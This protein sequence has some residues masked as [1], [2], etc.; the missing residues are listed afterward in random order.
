MVAVNRAHALVQVGDYAGAMAVWEDADRTLRELGLVQSWLQIDEL[1]ALARAGL[2]L[3]VLQRAAGLLQLRL[4]TRERA[5]IELLIADAHRRQGDPAAA[6]RGRPAR[7]AAAATDRRRPRRVAG[8]GDRGRG[9]ARRRAEGGPGRR[10]AGGDSRPQR[11]RPAADGARREPPEP[12]RRRP[13]AAARTRARRPDRRGGGAAGTGRVGDRPRPPRASC[14]GRSTVSSQ[15][16]H[17]RRE[18][19]TTRART[20]Q[21][22]AGHGRPGRDGAARCDCGRRRAAP[23]RA[24]WRACARCSCRSAARLP[25]TDGAGSHLDFFTLGARRRPLHDGRRPGARP[26]TPAPS[27]TSRA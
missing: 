19:S 23:R 27:T 9:R 20:G 25:S 15:L 2:A 17:A 16:R 14:C 3:T 11:P 24:S 21:R 8:G 13:P 10:R 6:L 5:A 22:T 12:A 1:E 4:P 18:R 26:R 7:P